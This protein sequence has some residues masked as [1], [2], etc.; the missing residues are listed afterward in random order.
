M[1]VHVWFTSVLCASCFPSAFPPLPSPP[2][3][4]LQKTDTRPGAGIVFSCLPLPAC[5]E[6]YSE[7]CCY[8]SGNPSLDGRVGIELRI[9]SSVALCECV[10]TSLFSYLRPRERFMCGTECMYKYNCM[11][12]YVS[13][14]MCVCQ[15][16]YAC[17]LMCLCEYM[18]MSVCVYIHMYVYVFRSPSD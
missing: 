6:M 7:V 12:L 16:M 9:S 18:C 15:C 10:C 2:S 8:N 13:A 1:S 14:C 11:S 5:Q 4:I 3:L 17:A